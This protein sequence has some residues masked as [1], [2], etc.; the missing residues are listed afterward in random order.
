V[1]GADAVGAGL[2]GSALALG[3]RHGFDVDHLAAIGDIAGTE[4]SPRRALGL[5]TVYAVAHGAVVLVLGIVAVVGGSYVPPSLDEVLGRVAGVTLLVMGAYVLLGL[6]RHGT[7]FR[8]RSRWSLVLD[9]LAAVRGRLRDR[10][11]VVEFE[12]DHP[13]D[14]R[15]PHGH[16]HEET[17]GATAHGAVAVG[18]R[19][20]HR[21]RGVLPG[22][23]YGWRAAAGVGVVHGV[24]A[25][26]PTQV[27]LFVAA[28]G[29]GGV[30][31]G[32]S[33]LGSFVVG[34][35]LANTAVAVV[36]AAG[37]RTGAGRTALAALA[38]VFSLVVGTLLLVG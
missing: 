10:A 26:T 18:H 8:V 7:D 33:V 6:L 23:G 36:A 37:V 1:L 5:S 13:H 22:A 25:E 30:A 12:H 11:A 35:L 15:R 20:L 4:R 3:L 34:L 16:D 27:V 32:L 9:A 2:L 19:H 28:A 31:A 14:H 29:A 24:G 21:H 38:G 17:G